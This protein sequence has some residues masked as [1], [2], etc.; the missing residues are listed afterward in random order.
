MS[1]STTSPAALALSALRRLWERDPSTWQQGKCLRAIDLANQVMGS[2]TER[3]DVALADKTFTAALNQAIS[4]V[5]SGR[6]RVE[7]E[8]RKQQEYLLD[9]GKVKPGTPEAERPTV[10]AIGRAIE[11]K[12]RDL[13][14]WQE[15][16]GLVE[17]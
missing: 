13:V 12:L 14:L 17:D 3:E 9:I 1:D 11:S 8:R 7:S 16:A 4:W 10:S 15:A 5:A 2:A 6:A